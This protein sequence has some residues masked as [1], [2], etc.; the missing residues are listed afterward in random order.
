MFR[1]T[2]PETTTVETTA[3]KEGGKGR[4]TPSRREAEAAAKARARGAKNKKEA[5]RQLRER[6]SQQ[7]AKMREG[8]KTG[9]E[10]FLPA[11]DQGKVRRFVRDR[12]DSRLCMAEFLLPLLLIIMVLQY[13]G[14]PTL[15]NVSNGLWTTTILL[16]L[17]DT[18]FLVWRLKKDLRER[19]PDES[20][21]G[22]VFYGILRA[23]QLRFLRLP[24]T[25]VKLGQKLPEHY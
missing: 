18:L 20:H 22:A 10:R 17:V 24:K 11:R 23:L 7:N 12:I 19:F 9:D 4:P 6:R 1:R 13:S 5:A 3:V 21:K 14:N 8:L 2:K 25:R 16:V 15:Q